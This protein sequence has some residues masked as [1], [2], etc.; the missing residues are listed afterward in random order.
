MRKGK[1]KAQ[2]IQEEKEERCFIVRISHI[3]IIIGFIIFVFF[4][5]SN[6]LLITRAVNYD[7]RIIGTVILF[8][9]FNV[10]K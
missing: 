8:T 1:R 7:L 5:Y 9:I 3:D 6:C 10:S 2:I 4:H